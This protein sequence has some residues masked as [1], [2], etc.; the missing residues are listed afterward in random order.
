VA[1]FETVT[2]FEP[3]ATFELPPQPEV[4]ARST[5]IAPMMSAVR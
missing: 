4:I 2:V 5:A 3:A 1:P